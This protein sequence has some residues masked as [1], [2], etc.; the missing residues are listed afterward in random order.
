MARTRRQNRDRMRRE[1]AG[2]YAQGLTSRGTTRRRRPP[3]W[4]R[5]WRFGR[6]APRQ[7]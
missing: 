1:R 5:A 4:S 7:P 2:L 6:A 3:S